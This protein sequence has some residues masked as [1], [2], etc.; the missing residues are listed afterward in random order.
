MF[1]L[2][3]AFREFIS[4]TSATYG[5]LLELRKTFKSTFKETPPLEEMGLNLPENADLLNQLV[6]AFNNPLG[7]AVNVAEPEF[8]IPP[9]TV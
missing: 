5:T 3:R 9:L 6:K 8:D 4:K 2:G 1:R 7:E